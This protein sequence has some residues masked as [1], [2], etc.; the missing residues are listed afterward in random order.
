MPEYFTNSMMLNLWSKQGRNQRTR[1]AFL[2]GV[3]AG[4]LGRRLIY[5]RSGRDYADAEAAGCTAAVQRIHAG[6][7]WKCDECDTLHGGPDA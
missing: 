1:N 4:A 5:Q 7:A 2:H 3:K 6:K